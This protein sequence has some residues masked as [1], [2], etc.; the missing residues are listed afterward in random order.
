VNPGAPQW[1]LTAAFRRVFDRG[2]KSGN[3][4]G[5]TKGNICGNLG[6]Y[7]HNEA[8]TSS[9]PAEAQPAVTLNRA[10][11]ARD[12]VLSL[13]EFGLTQEAIAHATG[14][15]PRSVRNWAQTSAIRPRAA[16]RLHDLREVVLM[17]AETLTPRGVGQWLRA[18]NRLLKGRPLDLLA[19]GQ[20][21]R[22]RQA[23]AAYVDGAYV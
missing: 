11:E 14:A 17:L 3:N 15:T 10:I 13:R 6:V 4:R 8:A 7:M 20:F 18:R 21:E 12:I 5:S 16:E 1:G 9:G 19:G 2:R 22:V 23:A